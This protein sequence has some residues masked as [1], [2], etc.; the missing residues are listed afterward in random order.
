ML[1]NYMNYVHVIHYVRVMYYVFSGNKVVLLKLQIY[2][3]DYHPI[4]YRK[5]LPI[6]IYLQTW[7]LWK[8]QSATK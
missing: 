8:V 4:L 6:N 2:T 1:F 3:I 7:F 5:C